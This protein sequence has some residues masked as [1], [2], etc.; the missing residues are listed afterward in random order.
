[1]L[2]THMIHKSVAVLLLLHLLGPVLLLLLDELLGQHLSP[3]RATH[4]N[5]WYPISTSI[6]D[7]LPIFAALD[8]LD[9]LLLCEIICLDVK[10]KFRVGDG[11]LESTD[12]E[13][14]Q[15]V[16]LE[17]LYLAVGELVQETIRELQPILVAIVLLITQVEHDLLL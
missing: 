2:L 14:E 7:A 16:G 11:I 17:L 6:F 1:M 3:V 13:S 10:I 9:C 12:L 15:R 4:F 8:D 5:I